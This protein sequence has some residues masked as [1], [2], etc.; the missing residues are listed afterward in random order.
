MGIVCGMAAASNDFISPTAHILWASIKLHG[1]HAISDLWD[2]R[3]DRG[4]AINKQIKWQ[5]QCGFMTTTH[6]PS[7]STHT[8]QPWATKFTMCWESGEWSHRRRSWRQT[9]TDIA[10]DRANQQRNKR[11]DTWQHIKCQLPAL[12]MSNWTNKKEPPKLPIHPRRSLTKL[13]LQVTPA[14]ADQVIDTA[15]RYMRRRIQWSVNNAQ[16]LESIL[17]RDTVLLRQAKR[18]Y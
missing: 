7:P 6:A 12:I 8:T 1:Q 10:P 18:S 14:T 5:Q 11:K 16:L 2:Q 15:K 3:C 9:A 4:W 17:I 13:R